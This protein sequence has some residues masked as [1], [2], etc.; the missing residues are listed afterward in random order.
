MI[1]SDKA[2]DPP[3]TRVGRR[4]F[5]F[6]AVSL[7]AL[8][9]VDLWSD[10]HASTAT[11]YTG[12]DTFMQVSKH[13]APKTLSPVT[14]AALYQALRDGDRNF[15]ANLAALAKQIAASPDLA[16]EALADELDRNKQ[17]TLR[18][19]L[20]RITSAWYL[21]VVGFRTYA[22]ETALMFGVVSDVLSPPSY[23][24]R[25][26]LYWVKSVSLPAT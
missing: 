6:A 16:I 4:R 21:G 2:N 18:D 15:D 8:G 17:T 9:V 12:L 7:A 13:V 20:N 26:P 11:D 14:G 25:G 23:V 5:V 1:A 24:R 19:T 10:V 3:S 22:Y